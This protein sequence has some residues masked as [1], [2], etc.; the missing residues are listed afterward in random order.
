M[1]ECNVCR[2]GMPVDRN[3]TPERIYICSDECASVPAHVYPATAWQGF[4]GRWY[5]TQ[6]SELYSGT[7]RMREI[8]VPSGELQWELDYPPGSFTPVEP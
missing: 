1:T 7:L 8:A 2:Y 3:P 5:E 6:V 4:T